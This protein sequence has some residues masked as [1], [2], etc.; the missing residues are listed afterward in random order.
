M[1]RKFVFALLL[2]FTLLV[3]ACGGGGDDDKEPT[4]PPTEEPTAPPTAPPTEE[5]QEPTPKDLGEEIGALYVEALQKAA[6]LVKDKPAV[7]EARPKVEA[8]KEEYIQKLFKL[9]ER[10]EALNDQDRATVDS[11]I[12]MSIT[13]IGSTEWYTAYSEAMQYYF[14]EDFEFRELLY[15]FNIIGQYASFDLLREQEPEEAVRLGIM[16]P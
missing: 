9:G 11:H 13:S 10:R 2:I 15:S 5:P 3:S 8:L 14:D 4:A 6:K 1:N 12:R 16:E 7:A